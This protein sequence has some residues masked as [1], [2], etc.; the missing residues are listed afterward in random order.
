[1]TNFQ[2]GYPDFGYHLFEF[3]LPEENMIITNDEEAYREHQY[4][5]KN[6]KMFEE[7]LKKMP[8]NIVALTL[9]TVALKYEHS[10]A[11]I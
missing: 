2:S 5:K 9:N 3:D 7:R 8:P 10:G 11:K 6:K 4:Y 1:V